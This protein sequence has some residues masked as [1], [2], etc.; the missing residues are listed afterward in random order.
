MNV[1]Q[2]YK[3]LIG[4]I[5]NSEKADS[6]KTSAILIPWQFSVG[7]GLTLNSVTAE[8]TGIYRAGQLGPGLISPRQML[9]QTGSNYI[10]GPFLPPYRNKNN[11][12]DYGQLP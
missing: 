4:I 5:A 8:E 11:P 2:T 6:A 10:V 12:A 7:Q 9:Q 3:G 1:Q